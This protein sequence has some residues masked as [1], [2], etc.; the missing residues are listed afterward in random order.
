MRSL[1][2]IKKAAEKAMCSKSKTDSSLWHDWEDAYTE[3]FKTDRHYEAKRQNT[4]ILL[5]A[6]S[7]S[8]YSTPP[9]TTE[10]DQYTNSLRRAV[11]DKTKKLDYITL[12]S[13]EDRDVSVAEIDGKRAIV[14]KRHETDVGVLVAA[15][16]T[17]LCRGERV[18]F[19]PYLC[20][21]EEGDSRTSLVSY[22]EYIDGKTLE[23]TIASGLMTEEDMSCVM[24]LL[25][26]LL[27][28][29]WS[30]LG[31]VH[32]DLTTSN[33]I[34]RRCNEGEMTPIMGPS[35]VVGAICSE[36]CPVLIDFTFS[37]TNDYSSCWGQV[38][39]VVSPLVDIVRLYHYF[40]SVTPGVIVRDVAEHVVSL[41]PFNDSVLIPPCGTHVPGL[42]HSELIKMYMTE[43]EN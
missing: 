13:G 1:R 38:S 15:Q 14:R 24:V 36:Y 4:S 37:V 10:R 18:E 5:Q 23:E 7:K 39:P 9:C 26:G 20:G 31:F 6:A 3:E 25:H 34:L 16:L 8:L 28:W 12:S 30:R 2:K 42:T 35:G 29:L 41:S 17:Q 11:L 40:R 32:G 21:W 19:V 43:V 22:F 33:I 27:D